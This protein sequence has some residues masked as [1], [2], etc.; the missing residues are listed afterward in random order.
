[1]VQRV[2][3]FPLS[4]PHW[5]TAAGARHEFLRTA[6]PGMMKMRQLGCSNSTVGLVIPTGYSFN[7]DA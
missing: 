3:H 6:L 2:F 4:K 5:M 1:M 7:L